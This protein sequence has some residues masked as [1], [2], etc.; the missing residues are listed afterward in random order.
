MADFYALLNKGTSITIPTLSI[1][2]GEDFE[3]EFEWKW[4]ATDTGRVFGH[5]SNLFSRCVLHQTNNT[6]QLINGANVSVTIN[7]TAYTR[8]S[9]NVFRIVRV[10]STVSVYLNGVLQNSATLAGAFSITRFYDQN[11][12]KTADAGMRY[13]KFY[14]NGVLER[15]YLSAT[16]DS[17]FWSEVA[18]SQNGT[19][20]GFLTPVS[21]HW[22]LYTVAAGSV[23][24]NGTI[25]SQLIEEGAS[26]SFSVADNFSGSGTPFAYSSI[27]TALPVGFTLNAATGAISYTAAALGLTAGHIIQ[28]TA[29]DLSTAQTN[30]FSID[31]SSA[32]SLV[33]QG[34]VT[35][36]GVTVSEIT[37]NVAWTY[38]GLDATGFEYSLNLGAP[39]TTLT[40]P[41]TIADLTS[42]Q[43]YSVRVRATNEYGAGAW[44]APFEF[45]TVTAV[46]IVS[47]IIRNETLTVLA[48]TLFPT[49]D[50]NSTSGALVVRF[51]NVTTSPAGRITL[52]DT[53][54]FAAGTTYRLWYELPNGDFGAEKVVAS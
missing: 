11:G 28:A 29:V 43:L 45:T 49:V 47:G 9:Y 2:D 30:T 5:N 46:S 18:S 19:I 12:F 35:I 16:N 1:A 10:G 20:F 3:L 24:F 26:G 31:V 6:L 7:I 34:T 15:H 51:T 36:T 53:V 38:V 40:N 8:T 23:E 32:A 4:S 13:F 42:G 17:N 48:N 54:N 44:S 14:R 52:T 21:Q 27:G 22:E 33:P 37:G 50:V 39:I 25:G 41:H